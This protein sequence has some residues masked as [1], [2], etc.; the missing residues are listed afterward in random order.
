MTDDG[1]FDGYGYV[2]EFGMLSPPDEMYE[3]GLRR[4]VDVL[5][6]CDGFVL[7]GVKRC[8]DG[9]EALDAKVASQTGPSLGSSELFTVAW[10]ALWEQVGRLNAMVEEQL[11]GED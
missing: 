3:V 10:H 6:W 1:L 2:H 5:K 8:E 9:E 4:A 7:V 11:P